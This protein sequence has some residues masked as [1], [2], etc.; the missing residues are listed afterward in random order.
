MSKDDS[1]GGF[2]SKVVKFVRH[3][4]TSWAD[5]DTPEQ[6]LL[7]PAAR[8]RWLAWAKALGGETNKTPKVAATGVVNAF[9]LADQAA[10]MPQ[11]LALLRTVASALDQPDAAEPPRGYAFGDILAHVGRTVAA[12]WKQ[13]RMLLGFIGLTLQT[14]LLTLPRPRRWRPPRPIWTSIRP[15]ST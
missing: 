7:D 14:L 11:R 9:A 15:T 10:L 8:T 6:A 12:V 2:L 13:Q 5:L 4:T 1:N 3:P